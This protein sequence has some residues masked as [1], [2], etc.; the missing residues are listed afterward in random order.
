MARGRTTKKRPVEIDQEYVIYKRDPD[1]AYYPVGPDGVF[2]EDGLSLSPHPRNP[3]QG[4]VEKIRESVDKNGWYGV[5]TVQK[6]TGYIL[7]GNH[8]FFAAAGAKAPEI[9]AVVRDV[10]DETATRILL[11]DNAIARRATLDEAKV[12]EL[13]EDLGSVAGTG[14]DDVLA[15]VEEADGGGQGDEPEGDGEG[16]EGPVA[17]DAYTPTYGVMIV[18]S[19]EDDQ[20]FVY[21]AVKSHSIIDPNGERELR[22]VAV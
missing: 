13:L 3:N 21:D 14:Y 12:A 1:G 5:V 9:P 16:D 8:R 4:D 17:D 22:V 2:E 18:C 11:A 20:R 19:S 6:S 7:A 15:A 10:D